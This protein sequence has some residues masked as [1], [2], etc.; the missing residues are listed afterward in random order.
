MSQPMVEKR[1]EAVTRVAAAAPH[2]V[3]DNFLAA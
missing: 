1:H 3:I 2:K